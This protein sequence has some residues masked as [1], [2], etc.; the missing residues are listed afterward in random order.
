MNQILH[1]LTPLYRNK[2]LIALALILAIICWYGIREIT[3]F[4]KVIKDVPIR[5]LLDSG[6]SVHERSASVTDILFRGSREDIGYLNR[7]QVEIVVDLRGKVFDGSRTIVL[8]PRNVRTPPRTLPVSLRP[9]VIELSL[10]REDVKEVPV[11]LNLAGS[12]PDG[13]EI[14]GQEVRPAS[15]TLSGPSR[16]L[17]GVEAVRTAPVPLDGQFETFTVK[18]SLL[19]PGTDWTATFIPEEVEVQIE[20]SERVVLA[21][22]ED[23]PV[24][25]LM[26][27]QS[28]RMAHVEPALVRVSVRGQAERMQTLVPSDIILH[29]RAIEL[30]PGV[31]FVLPVEPVT[32]RQFRVVD[33]EPSSVT[34]W[35]E[36]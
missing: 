34:V 32:H 28:P 5:I 30:E 21:Q 18:T 3:S 15:V 10:D 6:W 35:V 12:L 1:T 27:A 36:E 13:F 2:S 8:D 24:R 17:A 22:V 31:R 26:E 29:V 14:D 9:N 4:E 25:V 11:R 23:V 33:I 16:R 7:E 19:Q 20:L